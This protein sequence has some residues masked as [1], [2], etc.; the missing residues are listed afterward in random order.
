MDKSR[1]IFQQNK[2]VV[3]QRL[4]ILFSR[5][6]FF[7]SSPSSIICIHLLILSIILIGL[8]YLL[9]KKSIEDEY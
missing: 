6:I 5:F 9:G 4:K 8:P 7:L 3:M 1:N 2:V